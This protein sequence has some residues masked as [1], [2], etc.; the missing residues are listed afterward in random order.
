MKQ[1]LLL[2]GSGLTSALTCSLISKDPV[3]SELLNVVVWDKA[4]GV[5]GRM[6]TT[7][8]PTVEGN[9]ADFGAQFIT[10][11]PDNAVKHKK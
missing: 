6:S 10:V 7:R 8:C 2:V 4:R 5:G 1:R 3:L 11:T 9:I